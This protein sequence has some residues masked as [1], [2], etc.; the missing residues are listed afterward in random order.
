VDDDQRRDQR[1]DQGP[2]VAAGR[3]PAQHGAAAFRESPGQ[4]RVADGMLGR[5]DDAADELPG[6]EDRVRRRHGQQDGV[7]REQQVLDGEDQPRGEP[8]VE[9]GRALEEAAD[10]SDHAQHQAERGV[11]DVELGD[12]Q[13]V[14]QRQQP[15]VQVL[16]R[17]RDADETDQLA[18]ARRSLPRRAGE[19]GHRRS[20]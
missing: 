4:H 10:R 16:Q 2:D 18:P 8:L 19:R 13:R 12:D 9:A 7:G 1:D 5:R 3:V 20:G 11:G 6:A 17:V 15:H 14:G